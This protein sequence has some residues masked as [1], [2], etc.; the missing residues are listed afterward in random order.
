MKKFVM[1]PILALLAGCSSAPP[2]PRTNLEAPFSSHG[3]KTI[4]VGVYGEVLHPQVYMLPEGSGVLDAVREKAGFTARSFIRK[5]R[6]ERSG[7]L[8]HGGTS[9]IVDLRRSTTNRKY[10]LLLK[11]G[12]TVY[13]P[14]GLRLYAATEND[15]PSGDHPA[16]LPEPGH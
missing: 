15:S 1:L 10:D 7:G 14:R 5:V 4:S 2:G 12:D 13:V 6:V 11:N 3:L 16:G 8:D 9:Y